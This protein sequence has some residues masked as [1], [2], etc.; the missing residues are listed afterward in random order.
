MR[1]GEEKETIINYNQAESEASVWT[2]DPKVI[3]T[4]R[5]M[6]E[7]RPDECKVVKEGPEESVEFSVPKKWV[8]VKPPKKMELSE[9]R[10]AQMAEHLKAWRDGKQNADE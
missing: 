6:A 7:E 2:F 4:L 3:R 9:E 8:K 1:T 10:K 5:K